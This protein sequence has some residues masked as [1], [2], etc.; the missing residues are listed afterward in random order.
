M[1]KRGNH[2]ILTPEEQALA[3]RLAQNPDAFMTAE[4]CAFAA[5]LAED[6]R[7][8]FL[9]GMAEVEVIKRKSAPLLQP[10]ME[11]RFTLSAITEGL[12]VPEVTIRNWL[13]RGQLDLG[14]ETARAKGKWR[15]FSL[16]DAVIIHVAFQLSRVGV[17]VAVFHDVA[18]KVARFGEM[19]FKGPVGMVRRPIVVLTNDGEWQSHLHH[20]SGPFRLT[21]LDIP[22][23]AVVLNVEQVIVRT[24]HALGF[25]AMVGTAAEIGEALR[26]SETGGDE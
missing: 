15:L 6:K 9:R 3:K 10:Y 2:S 7:D 12:G 23:A 22:P 25:E 4:A 26:A 14:A 5:A 13:T 19:F 24:L 20:D 8:D 11:P 1:A 16:R 21:D 18:Q 17:P